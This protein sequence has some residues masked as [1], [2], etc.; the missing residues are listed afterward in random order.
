MEKRGLIDMFRIVGRM[1]VRFIVAGLQSAR[2]RDAA[3]CR[4]TRLEV[5]VPQDS[6]AAPL[7]SYAD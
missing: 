1:I 3:G 4:F 5:V 6:A 7:S 2:L